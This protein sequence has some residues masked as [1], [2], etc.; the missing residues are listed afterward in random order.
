[1]H[2]EHK[3]CCG[4]SCGK[5]CGHEKETVLSEKEKE[6]LAELAVAPFQPIVSFVMCSSESEHIASV[7]LAPVY[8][9]DKTDSLEQVKQTGEVIK[10]LAESGILSLDYDMPLINCDYTMFSESEIY[11]YFSETVGEAKA[12]PGFIFDTAKMEKGSIAL[13]AAGQEALD[14]LG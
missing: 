9:R 10:S 3:G 7:A 11:A 5:C 8:L 12:K 1:M 6:F 14:R 2:H 4:H 13:T